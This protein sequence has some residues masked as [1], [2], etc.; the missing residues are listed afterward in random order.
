[1]ILLKE[2]H[3]QYTQLRGGLPPSYLNHLFVSRACLLKNVALE[4]EIL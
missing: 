4:S 2:E 3:A 1:M